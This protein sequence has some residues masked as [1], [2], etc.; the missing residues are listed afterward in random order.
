MAPILADQDLGELGG[1]GEVAVVAEADAVGRVD[2]ERLRLGGAVAAGG[3]VAHVADADVAL[4]L[5]HVVLLEHIAHQSAAL[6]HAQLAVARGG[7]DAGGV[8]AAMLQHR[9]RIVEALID[10]ARSDD[11]DDAAHALFSPSDPLGARCVTHALLANE[12]AQAVRDRLPVRDQQRLPPPVL[13]P[14]AAAA[15]RE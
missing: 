10:R 5:E 6:A 14:A 9:E 3:R 15:G 2:V 4:E 11:A 13:A 7:G 12:R 1:V 8:L